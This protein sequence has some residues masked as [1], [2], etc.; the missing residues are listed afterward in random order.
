M[1]L[2]AALAAL[3]IP[4][5]EIPFV[6]TK[7]TK[8]EHF[9]FLFEG[10]SNCGQFKTADMLKA[11]ESDGWHVENPE[12]PFAYIKAAFANRE[13]LLDKVKQAAPLVVI[14]R[15]GKFAILSA[16]ASPELQTAIFSKL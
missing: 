11:W 7:S 16:N 8:G 2:A 12:H 9:V 15:A 6:S 14:E 4:F 13:A 1:A 3:G 10:V 5:A